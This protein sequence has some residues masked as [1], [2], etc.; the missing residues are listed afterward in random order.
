MVHANRSP[1]CRTAARALLVLTGLMATG[2]PALAQD[3]ATPREPAATLTLEEALQLARRNNPAYLSTRNDAGVADWEVREAYGRLLPGANSSMSFQWQDAGTPRLG[4]FTGE[5]FGFG[6]TTDYYSSSYS[7]GLSYQVSGATLLGPSQAKASRRATDA[8]IDAAAFDLDASVTRQ[9]L[10]VLRSQEGV[11]L[12][13]AELQRAREN[14]RLATARVVVGQAIPLEGRQAAVDVGR[15]E[16]A[17]LQARNLVQ[18]DRLRLIQQLGIE[19]DR[20]VV[21]TDT[22]RVADIP[23]ELESLIAQAMTSQP[24]LQAARA[25]QQAAST[26]VKVARTAYLPSLSMSA[27]FSGYTRQAGDADYLVQQARSS[28]ESQAS[29]CQLLNSISSGLST[30]L[31][32]TPADCSG[33]VLTQAQEE[34]IRSNNEVFPFDFTREPLGVSLQVSLPVF[35]G[36]TR[37]RQVEQA[38]AQEQDAR[39][40]LRSNELMVR[41]EVSTA[42]LNLQTARQTVALEERNRTLADDQLRLARER[43]RLGAGSFMELQDAEAVKARADR[44]YIDAVYDFHES[45]ATLE[46]NSGLSLRPYLEAR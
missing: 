2:H 30:P 40:Q 15:A 36:F 32:G 13:E 3:P 33:F 19:L 11:T 20:D 10:A 37:E 27:G 41:T 16:V 39:H 38:R 25:S 24:G 5:D 8:N 45:L 43:Y 26:G 9:Y 29:S 1:G 28:I 6:S 4:I 42:Y 31:P 7:L 34:R 46:A 23:W 21:L 12:A 18:T 14:E 44:A 35:Q 22:F 17:L